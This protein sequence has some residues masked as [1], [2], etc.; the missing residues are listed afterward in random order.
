MIRSLSGRLFVLANLLLW[1]IGCS[2]ERVSQ[3]AR[4]AAD[5]Q[6]EQN[7]AMAE[8]QGQV[9]EGTRKLVEAD[10]QSRKETIGV[11]R[12]LQSERSRLD[13]SWDKLHQQQRNESL[14]VT[15]LPTFGIVLA[16]CLLLGFCWYAL[17]SA[18]SGEVTTGDLND[19]LVEEL[20]SEKPRLLQRG[21]ELPALTDGTEDNKPV[22]D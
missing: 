5:R 7:E 15:F 4:E 1:P 12:E 3:I 8:L 11:H 18:R 22:S 19:L 6:A 20:T 21:T 13:Q 10:A 9:A 14:L 2:D 16:L 17:F